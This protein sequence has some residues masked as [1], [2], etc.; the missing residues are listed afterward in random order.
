MGPDV[1]KRKRYHAIGAW[2][3]SVS[4]RQRGAWPT[5]GEL[6]L[7]VILIMVTFPPVFSALALDYL[8][9][10]PDEYVIAWAA[11]RVARGELIYRDFFIHYP[12]VGF[13]GLALSFKLLGHTLASL[14]IVQILSAMSLTGVLY[15]LLRRLGGARLGAAAASLVFPWALFWYWPVPS[16]YWLC[17]PVAISALLLIERAFKDRRR[18][19]AKGYHLNA[20]AFLAGTLAGLTG[21]SIQPL[22]LV[23]CAWLALR[24][25]KPPIQRSV[26]IALLLGIAAPVLLVVAALSVGGNLADAIQ[27]TVAYPARAYVQEGGFNDPPFRT[28]FWAALAA[29]WARGP[30]AFLLHWVILSLPVSVGLLALTRVATRRGPG[31]LINLLMFASILMVYLRGRTDWVHATFLL[32]F[33]MVLGWRQLHE[34]S[35]PS[36]TRRL[37]YAWVGLAL[38]LGIIMWC[39]T[40]LAHKADGPS[41]RVD[42]LVRVELNALMSHLPPEYQEAPLLSLPSGSSIYFFRDAIGPPWDL[43]LPPSQ[44]VHGD[45]VYPGL[46]EWLER[47]QV[48]VVI[49]AWGS[50]LRLWREPSALSATLQRD[51]RP[52]GRAGPHALILLRR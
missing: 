40:W 42:D 27:A 13:Y 47:H 7:C 28:M 29:A 2:L 5:G 18:S 21:L 39:S 8:P 50:G 45:D 14:R 46:S 43:V 48:P 34:N 10:Q 4:S 49:L 1:E 9:P 30:V 6:V 19:E 26:L 44:C 17:M 52:Y 25:T 33:V 12:P 37:G 23:T 3:A 51:Y 31:D 20:P 16:M 22:G 38:A 35:T 24:V 36:W 32:I 41:I 15:M 11:E